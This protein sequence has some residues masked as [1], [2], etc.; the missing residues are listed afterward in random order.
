[1]AGIEF[2]NEALGVLSLI[3]KTSK[4]PTERRIIRIRRNLELAVDSLNKELVRHI[5]KI[6]IR[7]ISIEKVGE[8]EIHRTL[9]DYKT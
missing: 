2:T 4:D 7:R 5:P 1:M 9:P 3:G 6:K 8:V